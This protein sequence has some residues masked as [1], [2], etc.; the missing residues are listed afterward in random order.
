MAFWHSGIRSVLVFITI[1]W[2]LTFIPPYPILFPH[3]AHD[4][5]TL[6]NRKKKVEREIPGSKHDDECRE[7]KGR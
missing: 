7:Y 3:M 6:P 2:F 1:T 5:I 4:I